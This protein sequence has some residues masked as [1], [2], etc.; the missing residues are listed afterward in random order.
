MSFD[1]L[2]LKA[3]NEEINAS[4]NTSWKNC[5]KDGKKLWNMIDWK[6]KAEVKIE[7]PAEESEI[8]RYFRDIFQ[9]KKTENHPKINSI[10]CDIDSYDMHIPILDRVPSME[11]LDVAIKRVG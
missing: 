9:S 1:R 5:K 6:G 8:L 10:I 4:I 3:E 2:A 11:E 7:E